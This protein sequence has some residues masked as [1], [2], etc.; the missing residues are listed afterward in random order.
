VVQE[1][2]REVGLVAPVDLRAGLVQTLHQS[3]LTHRLG[4]FPA[5]IP[6]VPGRTVIGTA[7]ADRR[8]VGSG[9]GGATVSVQGVKERLLG[10]STGVPCRHDFDGLLFD[11]ISKQTPEGTERQRANSQHGFHQESGKVEHSYF[12]WIIT[13]LS[14]GMDLEA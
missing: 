8:A 11:Q 10:T 1:D 5:I 13:L 6:T 3:K 9:T 2:T 4:G 7:M 12:R 14:S